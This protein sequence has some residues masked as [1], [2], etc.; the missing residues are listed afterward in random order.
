M[1]FQ[2]IKKTKDSWPGIVEI[3]AC[4][5]LLYVILPAVPFLIP[6]FA[7]YMLSIPMIVIGIIAFLCSN[8]ERIIYNI[9]KIVLIFVF[10]ILLY[11]G[12][13]KSYGSPFV[14]YLATSLLYWNAYFLGEA[15]INYKE[16]N[17]AKIYHFYILIISI[18]LKI[19]GFW[20]K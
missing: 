16:I 19:I 4:I 12:K 5:Y 8:K 10:V 11:V 1:N 2:Y 3:T 15:I 20:N 17:L 7:R 14:S 9:C 18:C 13:W 6:Q